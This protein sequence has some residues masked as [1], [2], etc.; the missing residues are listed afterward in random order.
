MIKYDTK[1]IE[2]RAIEM[3]LVNHIADFSLKIDIV[4]FTI[5]RME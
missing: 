4:H 5:S 1:E 2:R 3:K